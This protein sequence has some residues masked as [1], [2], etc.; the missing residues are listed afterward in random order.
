MAPAGDGWAEGEWEPVKDGLSFREWTIRSVNTYN[1]R[2]DEYKNFE[3]SY[4]VWRKTLAVWW[5]ESNQSA[6]TN[7]PLQSNPALANDNGDEEMADAEG[8]VDME[9]DPLPHP[10]ADPKGKG[11]QKDADEGIIGRQYIVWAPFTYG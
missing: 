6:R 5:V 1:D 3:K 4:S 9:I 10:I 7:I 2:D 8:E 11:K